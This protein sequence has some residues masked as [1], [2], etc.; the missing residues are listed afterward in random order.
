MGIIPAMDMIFFSPWETR[1]TLAYSCWQAGNYSSYG[2]CVNVTPLMY[3]QVCVPF[4]SCFILLKFGDMFSMEHPDLVEIEEIQVIEGRVPLQCP[5]H[6]KLSNEMEMLRV[7]I[8]KRCA[9]LEEIVKHSHTIHTLSIPLKGLLFLMATL[10][11]LFGLPAII[12]P[13]KKHAPNTYDN[14]SCCTHA[15]CKGITVGVIICRPSTEMLKCASQQVVVTSSWNKC[16]MYLRTIKLPQSLDL[17]LHSEKMGVN[18]FP[19]PSFCPVCGEETK[20]SSNIRMHNVNAVVLHDTIRQNCHQNCV[21]QILTVTDFAALSN[22]IGLLT[23]DQ[24]LSVFVP[25]ALPCVVQQ[26]YRA[27]YFDNPISTACGYSRYKEQQDIR[28]ANGKQFMDL[29]Q[30]FSGTPS[31]V[32]LDF[33]AGFGAN[34]LAADA[35]GWT[36]VGIEASEYAITEAKKLCSHRPSVSIIYKLPNVPLAHVLAKEWLPLRV[37]TIFDVLEHIFEPVSLLRQIRDCLSFGQDGVKASP[38]L[39]LLRVPVFSELSSAFQVKVDHLW[40][41]SSYWSKTASVQIRF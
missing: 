26:L 1:E 18:L 41:A 40:Y 32:L 22:H 21:S 17:A 2:A 6:I 29:I 25:R 13:C 8:S 15:M 10:D 19:V 34:V 33:G 24:C 38:G 5:T 28:V 39:L 12:C 7:N 3:T 36:A 9:Q 30:T 4:C 31:G 20:Q 35:A 23:C 16:L 11:E 14:A 37:V 27:E